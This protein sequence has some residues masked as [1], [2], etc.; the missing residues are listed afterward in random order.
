MFQENLDNAIGRI[1]G[2]ESL[3]DFCDW[4]VQA[5]MSDL[6]PL[7][8]SSTG[9]DADVAR[10]LRHVARQLWG[11]L[12][13]P[14]NRWRARGLPKLERNAPCHCG[15]GRKFKQCCAEFEHMP[16]P[17]E[18]ESLQVL[19]LEAASPE[20]L[21]GDKLNEV[22]AWA[23][24]HAA[25][26]WNDADEQD[27][28]ISLL[29]PLFADL[30]SQNERHEM[31]FDAFVDALQQQ[32]QERERRDL[33]DHMTQH[34]NKALATAAR[35]R[36]V[37]ILAD[38]GEM[39]KAWQLFQETSRFNPNDP[40][41]W[42]LELNLLLSQGRQEEARLRAPLLAARARQAGMPDLAELLVGMAEE[43][44]G[45]LR[46]A[47]FDEV[48]DPDEQSL[49]DLADAVP[50]QL[51][52]KTLHSL[53][54]V[55]SS[56]QVE[57]GVRV[58]VARV[59]PVQKMADL[60]RRWQKTFAVGKP[61]MTWFNGDV[62]HL[63]EALPEALEFLQKHPYA[64]FSAEVLDDLLMTA[65]ALC[66]DESPTPVLDAAQRLADHAVAVL[67]SLAGDAQL[68]WSVPG[69]R[70]LLR[71][72]A[73]AL[74]LAQMQIDEESA[75]QCLTLGLA[76]NPH[77][78]HGWRTMLA[79]LWMAQG[80]YQAALD[81]MDRYPQ[82]MPPAEHRRALALFNLDRQ[83]EAEAVLREAHSVYPRYFKALLPNV[84]DA[85]PS[86]D[87]RGYVLGG[88]EAAW[89]F[90]QECRHL[91]VSTGAL[92]WAQGLKLSSTKP[93]KVTKPAPPKKAA[94]KTA[95]GSMGMDDVTPTFGS[96]QEKHLRKICSD[97]PRLH[98]FFQAL[99]WSPQLIMPK[100]WLGTVMDMHDRMPN[101]RTEATAN[102]ALQDALEATM[103]LYNHLQIQ[104]IDHLSQATPELDSVLAVVG[105][106]EGAAMSWAAGFVQASENA[107]TAWARHGH[108]VMGVT[109][110]FG[111][112]RSLA[113]RGEVLDV[114]AQLRDEHGK[115]DS[116]ELSDQP[117]AWSDL[118]AALQDL[119]PVVR[120]A[121]S[122]GMNKG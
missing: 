109:G 122:A 92:A 101:S 37:S 55:E 88:D 118:Q 45:F 117:A 2:G 105:E 78:N 97:Y 20:W 67:R 42:H 10:S 53:Y 28:T 87:E 19:A 52:A 22:P 95:S 61:E 119:W 81:L 30:K 68:H 106:D 34:P 66:D 113:A 114:R 41:L 23:L 18:P 35:T 58:D 77:D 75:L 111:R 84:M 120:Q 107:A 65:L 102:K 96:K 8:K 108:K 33:I 62:D 26:A 103:I 25:M 51:D 115:L 57:D 104:V 44:I 27:R 90:R 82:D 69:H 15:S 83:S 93:A 63:I 91:W 85:P 71:C 13:Y 64:W 5:Q 100:A 99:A 1:L 59:E 60:N 14:P 86:E 76:L 47:V 74:E 12:P 40:Q 38:E 54:K 48:D 70:P 80:D 121:R 72:L 24:G 39:D 73:I 17:L 79:T 112:L 6:Q 32:G 29:G 3:N 46:D 11:Q 89:Y 21:T 4:F 31:A 9:A 94:K 49:I 56:S 16:F 43:G 50:E 98:G 110:S 36:L 116:L 7:N